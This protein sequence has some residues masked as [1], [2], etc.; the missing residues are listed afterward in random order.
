M[1]Q[2]KSPIKTWNLLCLLTAFGFV[3]VWSAINV[4]SQAADPSGPDS[5]QAV[6]QP[7]T[8]ETQKEPD[9]RIETV[10]VAGGAEI[11]TIFAKIPQSTKEVPMVSVLRDTL[12]DDKPENDQLRYLWMLTYTKGA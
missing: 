9:L 7:P 3:F 4:F 6:T 5:S 11:L 10:P 12:G 1:R 8:P 2:A